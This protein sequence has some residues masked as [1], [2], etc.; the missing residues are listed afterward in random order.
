MRVG[1]L[2]GVHSC[3]GGGCMTLALAASLV[4]A[5]HGSPQ[6]RA[7]ALAP[8]F[9]REAKAHHLPVALLRAVSFRESTH[10]YWKVSPNGKDHGLMGIRRGCATRGHDGLTNEQLREP[11][12]NV[13]L[14]AARLELARRRCGNAPPLVYLGGYSG[15]RKCEAT[16]YARRVLGLEGGE[17]VA[18]R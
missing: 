17:R 9:A 18:A 6:V 13:H 2:F 11:A 12:I 7:R 1:E 14:G 16:A 8:V 15:H 10:R 3:G 4:A 5:L